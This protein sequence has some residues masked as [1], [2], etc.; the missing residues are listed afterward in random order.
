MVRAGR[1][2]PAGFLRRIKTRLVPDLLYKAS[3]GAQASYIMTFM[4]SAV[5]LGYLPLLL[6]LVGA[7]P[8][9]AQTPTQSPPVQS[10]AASAGYDIPVDLN[11]IKTGV[12]TPKTLT[13]MDP[14]TMRIYVSTVAPFP[15]FKD[16]VGGFD[17][18]NGAVPGSGMTHREF[19]ES[20]RPNKMYSSVGVS[21]GEMA[22]ATALMFAQTKF[23]DLLR[24]GALALREA[25]TDAERKEIQARIEKELAALKGDIK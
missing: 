3:D 22:K 11:K 12:L 20:T 21:V 13:L 17:L 8:V 2:S 4:F 10:P 19:V 25:K 23:F 5:R 9:A 24:K 14:D 16:I 1:S 7:R 18:F 15:K 6:L